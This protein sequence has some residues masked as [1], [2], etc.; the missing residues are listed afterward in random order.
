LI[1]IIKTTVLHRFNQNESVMMFVKTLFNFLANS[2]SNSNTLF[3]LNFIFIYLGMG[4]LVFL[5]YTI[6]W[7]K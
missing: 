5:K 3:L 6:I 1:N 4:I 7:S 2:I